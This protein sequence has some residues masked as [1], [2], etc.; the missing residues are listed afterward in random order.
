[1][2]ESELNK[3][4]VYFKDRRRIDVSVT[5]KIKTKILSIGF[6][7]DTGAMSTAMLASSI[8]IKMT[9]EQFVDRYRAKPI[10]HR[11]LASDVYINYYAVYLSAMYIGDIKL[12][13]VRVLITFEGRVKVNLLGMDILSLFEIHIDSLYRSIEFIETE[14]LA[15]YTHNNKPINN[16]L[17]I[18][19][20]IDESIEFNL[21]DMGANYMQKLI[22][23]NGSI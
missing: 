17:K 5:M 8:G 3:S 12:R 21:E 13:H 1:M 11:G 19:M 18:I 6:V 20:P 10:P 7:V 15:K 16:P 9:E 4:I 2:S 23:N 22:N 14:K